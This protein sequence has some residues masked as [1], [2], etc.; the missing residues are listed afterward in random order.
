VAD[1]LGSKSRVNRLDYIGL[2]LHLFLAVQLKDCF[3]Q[4]GEGKANVMNNG[5][6]NLPSVKFTS[7]T[8]KD[9]SQSVKQ[10]APAAAA[11]GD[12]C[13]TSVGSLTTSA[14][15]QGLRNKPPNVLIYCGKKDSSRLYESV[16]SVVCQCINTSRYTV[17]HLKHDQVLTTPWSDNT[18]LLIIASDKVYDGVDKR[19]LD[20]FLRGGTLISFGSAFDALL[21]QRKDRATDVKGLGV[22][23]LNYD[24][25]DIADFAVICTRYCYDVSKTQLRN[26]ELATL[27]T[28]RGTGE[29]VIIEAMIS[30]NQGV[31]VL[32]QASITF[33]HYKLVLL[34]I[35]GAFHVFY[36][37][38]KN[39]AL[40]RIECLL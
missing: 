26:V 40:N 28:D 20:Y 24:G 7:L 22:L 6:K 17:Y 13:S 35:C 14:R 33:F 27:A 4:S 39:A 38:V 23:I 8:S 18:A 37:H 32:S 1:Y 15:K 36:L 30:G 11:G 31:A 19:F 25:V 21:V 5:I 29:T 10:T 3:D 9:L 12:S 34:F 16:K 2:C